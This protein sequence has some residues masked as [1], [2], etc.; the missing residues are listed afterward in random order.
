MCT[1]IKI[2]KPNDEITI[3][4]FDKHFTDYIGNPTHEELQ[5]QLNDPNVYEFDHMTK[6]EFLSK[7]GKKLEDD[8][9]DPLNL[10][11]KYKGFGINQLYGYDFDI[12]KNEFI[13]KYGQDIK[14]MCN[15]PEYKCGLNMPK[16]EYSEKKCQDIANMCKSPEN[17][18]EKF[19]EMAEKNKIKG[20]SIENI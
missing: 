3:G 7:F 9:V 11:Y 17:A 12:S 14:D 13:K 2:I 1:F 6:Q 19:K 16:K 10:Y 15:L 18:Y 8:N 5:K 20:R 4:I